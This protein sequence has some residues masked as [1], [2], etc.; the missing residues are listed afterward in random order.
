MPATDSVPTT[1]GKILTTFDT[2]PP[3]PTYL[4][5]FVIADYGNISNEHGNVTV[6]TKKESLNDV[7]HVL[8]L[9]SKVVEVMENYTGLSYGFPRIGSVTLPVYSAAATEHWGLVTYR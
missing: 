8:D 5:T 3:M 2:T 6:F 7:K 4:L 1:D 9:S